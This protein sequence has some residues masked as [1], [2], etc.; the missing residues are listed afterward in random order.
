MIKYLMIL[1]IYVI[2]CFINTQIKSQDL[3][4][5]SG[6]SSKTIKAGTMLYLTLPDLD[7]IPCIR[8]AYHSISG[9]LVSSDNDIVKIRARRVSEP[10]MR[11]DTALGQII[12][13]YRKR[14]FSP[15]VSIDMS[16]ILSITKR[17]KK[18]LGSGSTGSRLGFLLIFFGAGTMSSGLFIDD[19]DNANNVIL[20]GMSEMAAGV[21]IS[22]IFDQK[23][24]F[25]NASCPSYK[26]KNKVWEIQ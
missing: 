20:V 10:I 7:S 1:F 19:A 9:Q 23:P 2:V 12:K 21:A 3:E 13:T 6:T 8:C 4:L 14:D 24:I 17:G 5:I 16:E 15:V 22:Q 11:N 18:Q 25:T 26:S